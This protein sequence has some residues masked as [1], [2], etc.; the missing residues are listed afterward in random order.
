VCRVPKFQ[1][2]MASASQD[3]NRAISNLKSPMWNLEASLDYFAPPETENVTFADVVF[4]NW[5]EICTAIVCSP[6]D[7]FAS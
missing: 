6:G 1:L 2:E 7:R 3:P 5:S 4:W